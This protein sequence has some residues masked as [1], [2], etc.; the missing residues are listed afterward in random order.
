MHN[1]V[2]KLAIA[3]VVALLLAV[4]AGVGRQPQ[5]SMPELTALAPGLR[6]GLNDITRVRLTG[7]ASA[8]IVT[9]EKG[10]SGWKVTE[11]SGYPADIVKVREFLLKLA[12]AT[13]IEQK[14]ADPELHAKLG[15]E[16]IAKAD[17]KGALLEIEGLKEPVKLIIGNY[18]GQGGDS[19][20]V[21]RADDNQSWLAKGNFTVDKTSANWLRR[22]LV[23]VATN[24]IEEVA[25]TA[26]GKTLR[27]FKSKPD[28]ANYTVADIPRG[29]EVSSEFVANGLAS[30]LSGLRFDDVMPAGSAEPGQ[31]KVFDARYRFFDGLEVRAEAWEVDGK[32]HARFSAS[33]DEARAATAV[34]AEQAK[35]RSQYETA[36]AA[37]EAEAKATADAAKPAEGDTATAAAA[38]A[39]T[40]AAAPAVPEAPLAVSDPAKD[41]D[42][43]LAKLRTEAE[44]M[45]KTFEGWTF[46]IPSFK[47]ANMN[48]TMDDM[49]KPKS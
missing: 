15:V 34:E 17:A 12:D 11:K 45:N 48:K 13:L 22:D 46:V 18:N 25:I 21:R 2:V 33:V 37:A 35:A 41:R 36:K 26:D 24:R 32:D 16:D 19:T 27:V 49:L 14:T 9:L 42:E 5:E 40:P 23:D 8:P 3:A 20:F 44:E 38:N 31:A 1:K 7:A 4:W 39:A 30:V 10:E 28:D 29:R 47:Y 6:E 43:R